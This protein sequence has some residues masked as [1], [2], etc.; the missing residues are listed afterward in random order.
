MSEIETIT[1]IYKSTRRLTRWYLFK[2]PDDQINY[3]PQFG[4]LKLNS[5]YW[6]MSHLI[7][8]ELQI[9]I[10][11][12][13]GT[14]PEITWVNQYGFGSNP[15]KAEATLSPLELRTLFDEIHIKSLEHI[16]SIP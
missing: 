2:I 5:A 3:R 8:A 10:N 7:W 6:E 15:D 11:G 16:Q 12:T 14:A 13:G 4:D 9:L 1:Q